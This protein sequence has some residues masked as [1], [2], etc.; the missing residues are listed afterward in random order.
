M[1]CW[2]VLLEQDRTVV[3]KAC[4]KIFCE[5][6]TPGS[7]LHVLPPDLQKEALDLGL[8]QLPV[9]S[10]TLLLSAHCFKFCPICYVPKVAPF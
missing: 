1:P 9:T 6:H 3:A 7:T 8:R 5:I 4:W 10:I 2:T